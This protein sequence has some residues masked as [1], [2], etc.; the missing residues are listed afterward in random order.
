VNI[1]PG[2]ADAGAALVAHPLVKKITFTGGPDTARRILHSCADEMKPVVLELGGKSA[3]I[4]FDDAD[5]DA[6]CT[7]GTM[8]SIAALSGQGC[9]LPTR[10]LVQDTI[11]DEVI[12][13]VAT[14]AG[15]IK[16]GH[17]LD[18]TTVSGPV[19]NQAALDRILGMIDRAKASG[20]RLITGGSRIGGELADGYYIEPTIFADVDPASELAQTEVFGPVLA[21]TK[22]ST[23]EEAIDIAN[24]TRYGLSGYIQ[25]NDLRR[26]HRVAEKLETG[27]V[28]VNGAVNL[29]VTRPFGGIGIS[30]TGKEGGRLGLQEFLQTK[31]I[32]IA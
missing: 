25:T 9:A 26:A 31:S 13:R 10:M 24:S 16:V 3:N 18:P 29:G 6:A 7:Q 22:F 11:Y 8:M 27:E 5:L 32:G 4:I 21:I 12:A 19:V 30:G 20:A 2:N 1:L 28:L 23:E 14:L 15:Y 17:P